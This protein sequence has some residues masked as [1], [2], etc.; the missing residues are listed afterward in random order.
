ME[1]THDRKHRTTAQAVRRAEAAAPAP[2]EPCGR[3]RES[4]PLGQQPGAS[5]AEITRREDGLN[6][7][8][9]AATGGVTATSDGAQSSRALDKRI[10][11]PRSRHFPP[12]KP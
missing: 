7:S 4:R 6:V 2:A 9:P 11:S 1:H 8:K 3:H 5:T 12:Y 10:K